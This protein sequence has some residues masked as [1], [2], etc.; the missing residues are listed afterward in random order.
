[1]SASTNPIRRLPRPG[2]SVQS[3][4]LER[5]TVLVLRGEFDLIGIEVFDDAVAAVKPRHS[6]V[7]DLRE[8]TFLDSSGLGAF[9]MLHERALSE[10]WSLVLSAPQPPVDMVLRISGLAQRLT[11]VQGTG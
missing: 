10:G 6:L 3:L 4:E 5:E 11:I 7:L 8:L 1:V 9:V 2:L